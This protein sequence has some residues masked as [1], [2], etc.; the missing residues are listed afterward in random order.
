MIVIVVSGV[1]LGLETPFTDP[2]GTLSRTLQMI[3][4]IST[5]IFVL[6]IVI[7]V[8]AKGFLFCGPGSYLRNSWNIA[9]F[10]IVST[11][12]ISLIELPIDVSVLKV[13]RMGRL[14]RPIRLI[15]RNEN[16]KLSI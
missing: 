13:M 1:A 3:D 7:K 2:D 14:L 12:L 6:E 8:I 9:D 4:T 10:L 11:A 15:S 5:T 16:L